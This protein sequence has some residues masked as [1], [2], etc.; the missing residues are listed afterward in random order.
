MLRNDGRKPGE[1]RRIKI[2]R[3]YNIHAEGSAYIEMGETKV[4]CT[5]TLDYGVPQFL[6]GS[7]SGW[8]NRA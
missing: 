8:V 4:V 2:V 3:N 6:R 5:A 1:L 7:G